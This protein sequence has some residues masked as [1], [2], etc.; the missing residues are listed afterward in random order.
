VREGEEVCVCLCVCVCVFVCLFVCVCV[1]VCMFVCVCESVCVLCVCVCACVCVSVYVSWGKGETRSDKERQGLVV[2]MCMCLSGVCVCVALAQI[3]NHRFSHAALF[4][5]KVVL[6]AH[7]HTDALVSLFFV[8]SFSLSHQDK[9][10]KSV[11]SICASLPLTQTYIQ[12]DK[13][14]YCVPLE[15]MRAASPS[16]IAVL[17]TPGSPI[18]TGLFFV[19]RDRT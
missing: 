7:C 16:A 3:G 5:N 9:W 10:T 8:S 11:I 12:T 1:C 6:K 2:Y 18:S 17:P 4:E 15:T 13:Q 19:L 14:M